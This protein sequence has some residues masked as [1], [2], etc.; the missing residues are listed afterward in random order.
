VAMWPRLL[1][2]RLAIGR[3]LSAVAVRRADHHH[4]RTDW[5]VACNTNW[6]LCITPAAVEL[7]IRRER[8]EWLLWLCSSRVGSGT[9]CWQ[10]ASLWY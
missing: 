3:W 5:G 8:L 7:T 4:R 2:R 1:W 6:G 9:T 10:I